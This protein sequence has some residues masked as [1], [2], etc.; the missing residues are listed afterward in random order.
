[1]NH[2]PGF[3]E[4]IFGHLREE[5]EHLSFDR[6]ATVDNREVISAATKELWFKRNFLSNHCFIVESNEKI[7]ENFKWI[8]SQSIFYFVIESILSS[9]IKNS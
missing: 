3:F 4:G 7:E 2:L 8:S 9:G 1:M 6:I 5:E